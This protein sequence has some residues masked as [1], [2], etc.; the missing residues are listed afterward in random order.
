MNILYVD[1]YRHLHNYKPG[2]SS[3]ILSWPSK[4][5]TLFSAQDEL[6]LT[7]GNFDSKLRPYQ[8]LMV[9]YPNKLQVKLDVRRLKD[10]NFF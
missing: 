3:R 7:R 5:L 9:Q 6:F 2:L 4:V 1:I 8:E 10:S